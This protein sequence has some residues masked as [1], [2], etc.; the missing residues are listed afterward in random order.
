VKPVIS[1]FFHLCEMLP[2]FFFSFNST[3]ICFW[4]L[5]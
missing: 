5:R 1:L 4:P 2:G 3:C